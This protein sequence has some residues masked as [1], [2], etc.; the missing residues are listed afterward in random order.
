[1][2]SRRALFATAGVATLGVAGLI[3][4]GSILRNGDDAVTAPVTSVSAAG[5]SKGFAG[6]PVTI[7]EYA[8]LQCPVCARFSQTVERQIDEAYVARGLVRLE[9]R[10]FAFLGSESRRAAEAAECA[11]EQGRFFPYRD[12]LYA[13][14]RGENRGAFS[15][16]RL[17]Q[18]AADLGLDRA[19]F[20]AA[21]DD[22]RHAPTVARQTA[23][24]RALGVKATP[25]F[26]ING[27]TLEGL[28]PFETFRTLIERAAGGVS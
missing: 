9:F 21:F 23:D 19:A 7:L 28:A 2:L 10:H 13:N 5:R 6:A 26:S 20:D 3:G 11:A 4:L 27:T 1:L 16:D 8:D 14:Q 18:I 22:G 12:A 15:D 25:T 24:G 17:K